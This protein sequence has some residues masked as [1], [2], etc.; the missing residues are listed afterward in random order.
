MRPDVAS[1]GSDAETVNTALSTLERV[2]ADMRGLMCVYQRVGKGHAAARIADEAADLH[3]EAAVAMSKLPLERA[4]DMETA[5]VA[6]MH[7]VRLGAAEALHS[8]RL[9]YPPLMAD[10]R[11]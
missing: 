3:L 10:S 5:L 11:C 8:K 9:V 6:A 1:V 4:E 7:L 2:Q